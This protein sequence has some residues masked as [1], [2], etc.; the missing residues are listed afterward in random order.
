[1]CARCRGYRKHDVLRE[2]VDPWDEF[3]G[4]GEDTYQICRCRGCE[5]VHFHRFTQV[6]GEQGT[7]NIAVYPPVEKRSVRHF[8][9]APLPVKVKQIYRET[10]RA[11]DAGLKILA[12]GG[13]R[14]IVEAICEDRAVKGKNLEGR[15]DQLVAS[16]LLAEPQAKFLHEERY[17]GNVALHELEPPTA[18][19]LELGLEIVEGLLR[20]IYILPLKAQELEAARKT[21]ETKNLPPAAPVTP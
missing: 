9:D 19:E 20:T 3:D 18:Q 11:Y 6:F 4:A 21:R 13:L 1:V 10:V 14:S 8:D 5:A 12:G 2:F 16:K 15:I 17:L 7:R